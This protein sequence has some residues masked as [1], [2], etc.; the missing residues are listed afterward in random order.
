M[1]HDRRS[2]QLDVLNSELAAARQAV[3]RGDYWAALRRVDGYAVQN[4]LAECKQ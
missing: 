1:D 2:K 4:A 3:A